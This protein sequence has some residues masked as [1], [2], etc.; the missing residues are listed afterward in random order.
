V[1]RHFLPTSIRMGS[2]LVV[3]NII[4]GLV[5]SCFGLKALW[6]YDPVWGYVVLALFLAVCF[7]LAWKMRFL[8]QEKSSKKV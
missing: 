8:N 4:S 1:D 2:T 7:V 3:L 5:L 6:D